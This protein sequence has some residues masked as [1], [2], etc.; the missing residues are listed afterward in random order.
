MSMAIRHPVLGPALPDRGWVPAP[1]Y[2]LRRDRVLR[3]M[4]HLPA[5][6]LLEIGGGSGALLDELTRMGHLCQA[7]ETSPEARALAGV[8]LQAYPNVQ[9]HA[10]A[11]ETWKGH[12]DYILTFEVLE[13]IEDDRAAL[14]NWANWLKPGG[15]LLMSVPAHQRRW[16]ASDVWAGHYRRYEREQL[17]ELLRA[18]GFEP[19]QTECYGFPLANMI[20]PVRN[21]MYGQ[22]LRRQARAAVAAEDK[23]S[24][25]RRSGTE[26]TVESRF[27]PLQASLLGTA[28]MRLN[29]ALQSYFIKTEIGTGYL[30]LAQRSPDARR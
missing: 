13:H 18:C 6:Q 17:E 30:V 5:G 4:R 26:R 29:F 11:Q 3:M 28:I 14:L 15:H 1:R 2:L 19:L 24:N 27:Y 8:M 10:A 7:I 9:V 12:F 23:A 16:S 25:T 20:A 22:D 21:W